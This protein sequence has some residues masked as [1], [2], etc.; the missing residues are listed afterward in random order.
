M[1]DRDPNRT[2]IVSIAE[3][4]SGLGLAQY[5]DVF[6]ENAVDTDV[7][8]DLTEADLEDLGIPLGDRKR[9]LKA[10]AAQ[11]HRSTQRTSEP[12]PAVASLHSEP[13]RRHL[14]ILFCDVVGSTGIAAELDP[15]D[16]S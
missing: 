1:D 12:A 8:F 6:V 4:L 16:L 14:T 11:R 2:A 5:V 15:E 9:I 7:L 10:I 3:W 13:E